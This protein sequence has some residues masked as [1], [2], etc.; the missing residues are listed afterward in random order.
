MF[1][2]SSSSTSLSSDQRGCAV[3]VVVTI[4]SD[5]ARIRKASP[6]TGWYRQC[7][8]AAM[9]A[10]NLDK[11]DLQF[12]WLDV[13]AGDGEL[14][15]LMLELFPDS[16]GVA[17]DLHGQPAGIN[18]NENLK[19]ISADL[20]DTEISSLLDEKF[21]VIFGVSILEHILH[22]E[23]LM[24]AILKLSHKG[25]IV[26]VAAPDATS[27]ASKILKRK[28]PYFLP[29]EHLNIPSLKGLQLMIESSMA[30]DRPGKK[31][32]RSP[33]GPRGLSIGSA[34]A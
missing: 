4:Q 31:G 15:R 21:D 27:I 24:Q 32:R 33:E 16:K 2:S 8:D 18:R 19:W 20:N 9:K 13:A 34:V 14:S 28:W 3:F 26:Y 25:T 29:G 10:A 7:I 17:V 30:A 11:K 6:L 5:T 12:S 23:T 22:P 1:V